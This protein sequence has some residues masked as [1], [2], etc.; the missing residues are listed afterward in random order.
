M[1]GDAPQM[2]SLPISSHEIV[3]IVGGLLVIIGIILAFRGRKLWAGLMSMIGAI[4]GGSLGY[5]FGLMMNS[6]IAAL[7]L[8]MVG[9]FIGSVLFGYIVKIALA[10]VTSLLVA[11]GAYIYMGPSMN[12]DT[13]MIISIV[14]LLVIYVIAYWFIQEI[15][16]LVTAIL[17]AI[18]I[19]IGIYLMGFGTTLAL[20]IGGLAFL[21]GFILQTIDYRRTRKRRA[22]YA[23]R[24]SYQSTQVYYQPP[25]QP[26]PPPQ[27]PVSRPMPP[28]PPPPDDMDEG[29]PP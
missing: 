22:T 8:S 28:P 3:L 2:A 23:A 26:A 29:T 25:P 16:A 24:Q 7:V 6:W 9:A 11:G 17:G 27:Q 18:L 5:L 21:A 10:F 19:G 1:M 4:I 12:Q 20:A 15:I 14:L 13:R